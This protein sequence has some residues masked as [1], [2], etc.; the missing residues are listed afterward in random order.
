MLRIRARDGLQVVQGSRSRS[1]L[2]SV[3]KDECQCFVEGQTGKL[4]DLIWKGGQF[5]I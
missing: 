2:G 4:S 1:G 3:C 5:K